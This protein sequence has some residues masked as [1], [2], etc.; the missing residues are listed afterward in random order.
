MIDEPKRKIS[1]NRLAYTPYNLHSSMIDE[2]TRKIPVNMGDCEVGKVLRG[3]RRCGW[4]GGG[5]VGD[6]GAEMRHRCGA[7]GGGECDVG[8]V[9]RGGSS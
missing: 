9:L 7:N 6:V 8:K 2:P 4:M 5:R 3:R 1:V